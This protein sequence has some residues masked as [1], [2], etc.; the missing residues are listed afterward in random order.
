MGKSTMTAPPVMVDGTNRPLTESPS[1]SQIARDQQRQVLRGADASICAALFR[2]A[3]SL[4]TKSRRS[5]PL[6]GVQPDKTRLG[7]RVI[8]FRSWTP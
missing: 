1:C 5:S 7:K 6:S 2:I 8:I 3:K 4:L